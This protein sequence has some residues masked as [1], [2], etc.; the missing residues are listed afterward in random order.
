MNT[1]TPPNLPPSMG[2]GEL[3]RL[4]V[5]IR[6]VAFISLIPFGIGER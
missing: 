1:G 6:S 2:E 3:Y 5:E 4:L